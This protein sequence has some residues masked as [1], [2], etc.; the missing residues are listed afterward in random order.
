MPPSRPSFRV[1]GRHFLLT[2]PQCTLPKEALLAFLKTLHSFELGTVGKEAH[3]DG[4]PHLHAV[5]SFSQRR[6]ITRESFFDHAG[7]HPNIKKLSTKRDVERSVEYACKDGDYIREHP[8]STERLGYG[9]ILSRATSKEDFISLIEQHHPRDAVLFHERITSYAEKKFPKENTTYS[10][11][12]GWHFPNLPPQLTNW[13]TTERLVSILSS[14]YR[15]SAATRGSVLF[16][17]VYSLST[18][19]N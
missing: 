19:V 17:E 9:D 8:S 4:S 5:V 15:H 2:Y 16:N 13:A 6:N 11:P 12:E 18:Y 14:S 1:Q 7:F 10:H 3:Q